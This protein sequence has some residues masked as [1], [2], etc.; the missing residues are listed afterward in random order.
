MSDEPSGDLDEEVLLPLPEDQVWLLKHMAGLVRQRGY[1]PLATAPIVKPTEQFFPD[2]WLGGERSLARLLRRLLHYAGIDDLDV[3]LTTHGQDHGGGPAGHDLG[4][5]FAGITGS[6]C[7]F[8]AHPSSYGAGQ[9]VVAAAC[10]AVAHAYRRRHRLDPAGK[11][12]PQRLIDVTTVYLGFGILTTD[13]AQ[14]LVPGVAGRFGSRATKTRLGALPPRAMG[15][16]LGA[17]A[18]VRELDRKG[19]RQIVRHLQA[20]QAGFFRRSVEVLREEEPA[21]RKRL[22]VPPPEEWPP[23]V[24]VEELTEEVD[25]GGLE[26]EEQPETSEVVGMNEG[27]PVFRVSRSMASRLAKILGLSALMLGAVASRSLP[28][29]GLTMAHALV[30]GAVLGVLGAALGSLLRESR[31]SEP[32]CAESLDPD[33]KICP[34]CRGTVSGVIAHPKDRL[35]A[36]DAL[37]RNQ[38]NTEE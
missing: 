37:A 16:L 8:E 6:V 29:L 33:A 25:D 31:C 22:G 13:A 3:R 9:D 18:V 4:I 5:W 27:R 1:E 21:V 11:A 2:P 20:N 17:Q 36:E 38:T 30:A 15:F 10:R 12:T 19:R 24:S 14:R 35:G 28:E 26:E 23:G 32:K 7:S 34:R